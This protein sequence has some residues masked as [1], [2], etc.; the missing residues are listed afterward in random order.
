[1]RKDSW[2]QTLILAAYEGSYPR[3][4]NVIDRGADV[5]TVDDFKNRS[6]LNI[7]AY[8]GIENCVQLLIDCGADLNYKDEDGNSSIAHALIRSNVKCARVLIVA[9]ADLSDVPDI[10]KEQHAD[11]IKSAVQEWKEL[12]PKLWAIKKKEIQDG[13]RSSLRN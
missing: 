2:E 3:M 10:Y 12:N 4:Q 6:V 1:M 11:L 8:D 7:V 13:R 9:G 5:N